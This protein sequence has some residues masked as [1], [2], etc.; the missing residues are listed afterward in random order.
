MR[1]ETTPTAQRQP[2]MH[3]W[4]RYEGDA[5]PSPPPLLS[6]RVVKRPS[7]RVGDIAATIEADVLA[8]LNDGHTDSCDGE[9]SVPAERCDVDHRRPWPTG[10]TNGDNMWAL[11]GDIT[12]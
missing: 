1:I 5:R 6:H 4:R 3:H 12:P 11:C 10:P 2:G 9:W 7:T 8:G